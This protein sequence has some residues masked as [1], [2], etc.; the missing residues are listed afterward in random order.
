MRNRALSTVPKLPMSEGRGG[1]GTQLRKLETGFYVFLKLRFTF[2]DRFASFGST[3]VT[4]MP[5][6]VLTVHKSGGN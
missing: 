3:L 6:A 5:A 4:F 2:I 1:M